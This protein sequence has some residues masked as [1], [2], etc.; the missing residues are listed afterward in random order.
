MPRKVFIHSFPGSEIDKKWI[1]P[2]IAS[3]EVYSEL[4]VNVKNEVLRAQK[5]LLLLEE[6]NGLTIAEIKDI[7]N[8]MVF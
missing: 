2:H 6:E 3:G 4:L 8:I 1:D 7:N 5:K